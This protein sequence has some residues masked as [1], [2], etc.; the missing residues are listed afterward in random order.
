MAER[1]TVTR[2]YWPPNFER[3]VEKLDIASVAETH[4]RE[5]LRS[6][7]VIVVSEK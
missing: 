7:S 3:T 4:S 5:K 2:F 1:K 6:R